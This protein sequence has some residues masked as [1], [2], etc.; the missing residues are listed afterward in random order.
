[1]SDTSRGSREIL[2]DVR[3]LAREYYLAT[4]RPLGVTA[5]IGEHEAQ[6]LLG[7][8]LAP[9]REPGSDATDH[10]GRKYQI[11]ARAISEKNGKSN[12]GQKLGSIKLNYP[13]DA[14]L[15]VILS[16]DLEAR[17]IH[18][19]E[20]DAIALA[21]AA[22]GSKARNTRGQLSVSKF[23]SIGRK[24]WPFDGDVVASRTA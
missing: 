18:E 7:L 23:K 20:R 15:L 3:K 11:K 24:V 2:G 4:G 12:P 9:V 10:T 21:L 6:N 22:P 8:E 1:M 16:P 13:W 19:A 5:E 17:E 14:V